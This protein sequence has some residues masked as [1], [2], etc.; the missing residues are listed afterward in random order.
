MRCA[1]VQLPSIGMGSKIL[2][3]YVKVAHQKGVKLLLLGEYVLN[4]FFKELLQT[5]VSMIREQS[6]HQIESQK[7]G[8]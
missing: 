1:I 4:P 6:L 8:T 5:P 7:F 3:N 2:E